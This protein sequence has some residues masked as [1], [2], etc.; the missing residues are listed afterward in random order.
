MWCMHSR[1]T[2]LASYGSRCLDAVYQRQTPTA[3]TADTNGRDAVYYTNG[4]ALTLCTTPT[5]GPCVL[6]QRQGKRMKDHAHIHTRIYARTH[7]HTLPLLP[8]F[9]RTR[10]H[11]HKH[12]YTQAH[13]HTHTPTHLHTSTHTET[14]THS[15]CTHHMHTHMHAHTCCRPLAPGRGLRLCNGRFEGRPSHGAA[16]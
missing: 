8:T 2:L 1:S 6:H 11:T 10:S 12:T 3:P 4:R 14:Q 13:R 16:T 15:T 9:S 5:A 7:M